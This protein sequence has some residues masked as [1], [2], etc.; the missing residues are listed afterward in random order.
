[1][2]EMIHGSGKMLEFACDY[3]S[4][5]HFA[6]VISMQSAALY[7]SVYYNLINY[8]YR[9]LSEDLLQIQSATVALILAKS[10][11]TY[12]MNI[13]PSIAGCQQAGRHSVLLKNSKEKYWRVNIVMI[14]SKA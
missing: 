3:F 13:Y 10:Q 12:S 1:M 9:S 4:L 14:R 7:C 8:Y 6:M 2:Q 11:V 5:C